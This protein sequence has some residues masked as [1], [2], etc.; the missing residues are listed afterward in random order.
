MDK[1]SSE[2]L[3]ESDAAGLAFFLA[4]CAETRAPPKPKAE[5]PCG[6]AQIATESSPRQH[7]TKQSLIS[8]AMRP[9][10]QPEHTSRNLFEV[11]DAR[12]GLLELVAGMQLADDTTPTVDFS[13]VISKEAGVKRPR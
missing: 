2:S 10:Q 9:E 8:D 7:C 4:H 12:L 11:D 6:V 1:S 5:S 13:A 3:E